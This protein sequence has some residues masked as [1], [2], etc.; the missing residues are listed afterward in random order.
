[1]YAFHG[2]LGERLSGMFTCC[3][4]QRGIELAEV[5]RAELGQLAASQIGEEAFNVL[6]VADKSGSG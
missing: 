5:L 4:A 3:I 1:M 2:V 6:Q